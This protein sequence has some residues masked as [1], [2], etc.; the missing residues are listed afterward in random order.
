MSKASIDKAFDAIVDFSGVER[1]LDAPLKHYSSGMQMRLAFAISAHLEP[2]IVLIDEVLAVGD[3]AFQ[4]KCMGK[5]GDFAAGGRTVLLV[6]HN[7]AAIRSLCR[8]GLVIDRGHISMAGEI[9]QCIEDYYRSLGAFT[10]APEAAQGDVPAR[11]R[12]GSIGLV[13][14]HGNTVSQGEGFSIAT[15][16]TIPELAAGLQVSCELADARGRRISWP[17]STP[18]LGLRRN[19]AVGCTAS[20][21]N[22]RRCG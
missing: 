19:L 5:L 17:G 6:S 21:R 20:R 2:S 1:F 13:G 11:L 16:L 12:F 9:E 18:S 3:A 4:Q 15:T 14:R 7:M 8:K 10:E 22:A